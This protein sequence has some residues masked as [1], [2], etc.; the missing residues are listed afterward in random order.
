MGTCWK[1]DIISVSKKKISLSVRDY[2]KYFQKKKLQYIEVVTF[3]TTFLSQINQQDCRH[4]N[5]LVC[6]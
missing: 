5:S 2:E 4:I 3:P 6:M 1:K